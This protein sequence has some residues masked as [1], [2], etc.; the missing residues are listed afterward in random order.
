M[1]EIPIVSAFPYPG[2][3]MHCGRPGSGLQVAEDG[4]HPAVVGV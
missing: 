3:G 1:T 4:E 2:V